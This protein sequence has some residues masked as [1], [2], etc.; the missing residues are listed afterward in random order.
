MPMLLLLLTGEAFA[1]ELQQ[2][3]T[4]IQS[5]EQTEQLL[6]QQIDSILSELDISKLEELYGWAEEFFEGA[7]LQQTIDQLTREGLRELDTQKLLQA[8]WAGIKQGFAAN[9]HYTV[10]ILVI[11]LISGLFTNLQGNGLQ[12]DAGTMA[13]WAA[14]M[15]C[16]VLAAWMLADCI[17]TVREAA[18]MLSGALEILTP[19]LTLLLTAMGNLNASAVLSPLMAALTGGIFQVVSLIVIP[20][21]IVKCILDLAS[22]ASSMLRLDGFSK[23][24]SS[25]VKWML[26][27]LF[28]VFLG[29]TALKGIAG[30]SVDGVYFKT[31]KFTVDKMVPIIGGMFSDT[32]DT[33]M[34]CS[35]IVKNAVGII[36]LI[37]ICAMMGAPLCSLI[38]TLFMLKLA[39]AVAGIFDAHAAR[40]LLEK[41]GECVTLLFAAL[42]SMMVMAFI[43]IAVVMGAADASMMMR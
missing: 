33:L 11:V 3:E 23:L 31:A 4:Q 35:L 21:V 18:D 17:Q 22:G 34:A 7:D 25:G 8:I 16:C 29:V 39:S 26:G 40:V 38:A 27:I 20:A 14:Y 30:A 13:E 24:L 28:V 6:E 19:I 15:I 41:L 42:L 1:S 9:W 12:G 2:E 5:E 32:L 43:F 37:A 10:Q 36:G